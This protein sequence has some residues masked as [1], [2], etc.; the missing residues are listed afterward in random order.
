MKY[1]RK[2]TDA[3]VRDMIAEV[4][5]TA[6]ASLYLSLKSQ[7]KPVTQSEMAKFLGVSRQRFHQIVSGLTP[8]PECKKTD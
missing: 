6:V 1:T 2:D 7:G 8:M 4:R 5:N 3:V